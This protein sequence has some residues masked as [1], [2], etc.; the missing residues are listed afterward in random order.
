MTFPTNLPEIRKAP[1]GK[2]WVYRGAG[3]TANSVLYA[4]INTGRSE[5][6]NYSEYTSNASGVGHLHYAELVDDDRQ[7]LEDKIE[8]AKS[9]IGKKFMTESKTY[10]VNGW[11]IT[12]EACIVKHSGLVCDS[13]KENGVCVYFT[14]ESKH[15]IPVDYKDLKEVV[16]PDHLEYSL[17]SMYDAKVYKDRIVVGCQTFPISILEDLLA[18][19]K[20]LK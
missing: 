18:L 7:T 13:V 6:W 2:R 20:E 8:L 12:N 16:E 1:K 3:W 11:S 4:W 10:K 5:A 14:T 15:Q 19:H 17:N 9:M